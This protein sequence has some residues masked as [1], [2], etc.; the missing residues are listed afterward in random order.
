[1]TNV[2][3]NIREM[4]TELYK[5]FDRYYQIP[6]TPEAWTEFW[7]A[8]QALSNKYNNKRL[9]EGC[10]VVADCISDRMKAEIRTE[11]I[12]MEGVSNNDR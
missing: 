7:K 4:W 6:N 5:L 3:T 1:M 9:T 10:C 8:A 12:G 11:Q 2:P